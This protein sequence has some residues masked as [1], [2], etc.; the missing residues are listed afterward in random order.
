MSMFKA[1]KF[2]QPNEFKFSS[3]NLKKIKEILKK[4]PDNKQQSAVMPLLDLAQRQHNNWI[5]IAAMDV[6][7][8]ILDIPKMKVYEVANFYTMYNKQ[9]VGK[10]LVQICRTSPCWLRGSDEITKICRQKLNL[11]I[12]QTSSDG[13]FTL[14]EVECLG[15]CVN[16]PVIQ[17]NDDY[18]EDLSSSSMANIIDKLNADVGVKPG[19]QIGRFSSEPFNIKKTKHKL[20]Q[21]SE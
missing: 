9:P 2:D 13:K 4:Y 5:P 20:N 6:I 1:L 12:G 11:D 7:A 16:A 18:Y 3:E 17:I 21:G 8:N 15:A 14:I 10:Y 19:S